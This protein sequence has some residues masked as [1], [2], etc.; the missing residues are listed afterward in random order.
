[1]SNNFIPKGL[2]PLEKLFD[3]N[4]VLQN[5]QSISSQDDIKEINIGT[6]DDIKNI[7]ICASLDPEIKAQ[8]LKLLQK[9]KDVFAWTYDDLKT[10]DTSLIQHKIPL[11]PEAKPYQQKLRR[12]NPALLPTIE[13]EIK[14]MLYAHSIL[15]L[16]YSNW[17]ANLVPV[18]KKN[19]EIRLCVDFRNLNKASLKDN[20]PL[21]KM[22]QLLQM[23]SGA[24]IISMLDGFSGYN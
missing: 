13:R 9:Y 3:Q 20:Y 8:Y 21:P 12:I 5:P 19:R 14:K 11:K 17:V 23:V 6:N 18:R 22:D 10:Y 16:R 1:M 4:D 7:K 2:I 24:Q 15:P